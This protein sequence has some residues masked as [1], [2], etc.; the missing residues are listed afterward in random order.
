MHYQ[1]GA[2]MQLLSGL[3]VKVGLQVKHTLEVHVSQ[4]EYLSEHCVHF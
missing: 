4:F 3:I 1:E 2:L